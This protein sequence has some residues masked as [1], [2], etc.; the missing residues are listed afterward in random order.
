MWM[1][2]WDASISTHDDFQTKQI[3]KE[4][5]RFCCG[6][7]NKFLAETDR[8]VMSKHLNEIEAAKAM[9]ENQEKNWYKKMQKISG[10]ISVLDFQIENI[11]ELKNRYAHEN[12]RLRSEIA[13]LNNEKKN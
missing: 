12:I 10:I 5:L 1:Q 3:V 8:K 6:E 9:I 2:N 4:K 7:I 11:Y 13:K